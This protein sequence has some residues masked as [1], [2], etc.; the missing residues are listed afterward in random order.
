[1]RDSHHGVVPQNTAELLWQAPFQRARDGVVTEYVISIIRERGRA[2]PLA[3][4][5]AWSRGGAQMQYTRHFFAYRPSEIAREA[6]A[7]VK[8]KE[9]Q[10]YEC[11]HWTDLRPLLSDP[12]EVAWDP[13]FA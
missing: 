12:R 8:A 11:L 4:I 1:M 6:W 2:Q 10:G 13:Q 7:L 9:S 3:L 5:G